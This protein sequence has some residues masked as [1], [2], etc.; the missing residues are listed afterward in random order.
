M[1][2]GGVAVLVRAYFLDRGEGPGLEGPVR[3][4]M[5]DPRAEGVATRLN[6]LGHQAFAGAYRAEPVQRTCLLT[7]GDLP[8]AKALAERLRVEEVQGVALEEL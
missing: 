1:D 7:H 8:G 6:R 5:Q 4:P 2:H 3:V